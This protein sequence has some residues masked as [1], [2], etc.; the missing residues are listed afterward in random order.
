MLTFSLI[1]YISSVL[2]PTYP[3]D[4]WDRPSISAYTQ[5]K[6]ELESYFDSE[7]VKKI[8]VRSKCQNKALLFCG[9][10]LKLKPC[11]VRP[12]WMV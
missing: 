3:Y 4:K 12:T 10:S 1:K 2:N 7:P 11:F 8:Q 6:A 5:I 9:I